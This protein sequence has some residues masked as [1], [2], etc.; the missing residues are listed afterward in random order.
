MVAFHTYRPS[1][2]L[3]PHVQ[4]YW[5][6]CHEGDASPP[7]FM[8]PDAGSGLIFTL[9]GALALDGEAME[10][11]TLVCGPAMRSARVEFIG[12]LEAFGIR[13]HP[14]HGY[15]FFGMPLPELGGH[16]DL[17]LLPRS[18]QTFEALQERMAEVRGTD[19]RIALIE[20]SLLRRLGH[21]RTWH[22]PDLAQLLGMIERHRGTL[23]LSRL[24]AHSGI[25]QR[26]LERLFSTQVG[27]TPKQFSRLQR[28]GYARELVKSDMEASMTDIAYRTGFADQA[29]F[30]HEF[31]RVMGI[32]P[33]AYHAKWLAMTMG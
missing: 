6:L 25:G 22:H 33:G 15:P 26:Q 14:G 13:F 23:P 7:R 9:A 27:F 28:I 12:P 24:M 19:E 18:L 17:S 3:A 32:T 31:R 2:A 1:P 16:R 8:H 11:A 21:C 10:M 30:T 4:C 29:H 5:H 20:A